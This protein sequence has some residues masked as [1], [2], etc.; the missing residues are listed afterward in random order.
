MAPVDSSDRHGDDKA[1][2]QQQQQEL[3][4]SFFPSPPSYYKHFTPENIALAKRFVARLHSSKRKDEPILAAS[5]DRDGGQEQQDWVKV[6]EGI[7]REMGESP[8]RIDSLRD[9]DLQLLVEAPDITEIEREGHWL[10]F[11]QVWPVREELPS[12]LDM[13][14]KQLYSLSE[15]NFQGQ[16]LCRGFF[17][18]LGAVCAERLKDVLSFP[19][20]R[21]FTFMTAR[22]QALHTLLH[23]ILL[24]YLRLLGVLID[25]PPSL[26]AEQ[27][28]MTGSAPDS[29]FLGTQADSLIDHIRVAAINIHHLCNEWRP[30]QARETLK[31]L[32]RAQIEERKA[33][34]RDMSA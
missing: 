10:S 23:T 27:A 16:P 14:V 7:L 1:T 20:P 33:R 21:G 5:E 29:S 2:G 18:L 30:I 25:G 34:T 11:G 19:P 26:A 31:L 15:D 28:R 6:Q 12:L 32:M 24:T 9:V 4:S 3:M 13:G 17:R 22:R 8:D